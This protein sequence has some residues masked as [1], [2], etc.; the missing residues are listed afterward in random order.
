MFRLIDLFKLAR[1]VRHLRKIINS[2]DW[3]IQ[4][5]YFLDLETESMNIYLLCFECLQLL[6]V[7]INKIDKKLLMES[8]IESARK[9]A[10]R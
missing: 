8:S 6:N 3:E 5:L 10:K 1:N 2:V 7:L 4:N 9:S